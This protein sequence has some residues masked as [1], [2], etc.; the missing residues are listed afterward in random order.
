MGGHTNLY[1]IN[2]QQ[3]L[4]CDLLEASSGFNASKEN[5]QVDI[6]LYFVYNKY[7]I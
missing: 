2:L 6:V 4:P 1:Q 3:D 5:V 7:L